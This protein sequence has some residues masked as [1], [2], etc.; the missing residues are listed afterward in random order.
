MAAERPTDRTPGPGYDLAVDSTGSSLPKSDGIGCSVSQLNYT[1][2]MATPIPLRIENLQTA[3]IRAVGNFKKYDLKLLEL[4][5]HEQAISHRIAVYLER[6]FGIG[7]KA[8]LNVDCE[9]SKHLKDDKIA[10]IEPHY[11]LGKYPRC[12]CN[13]CK[14]LENLEEIE[15]KDF[16]PD[17]VVHTRGNDR[18]NVVAL[19]VKKSRI[20]PFDLAKLRALTLPKGAKVVYGYEL[21]VFLHFQNKEPKYIWFLSGEISAVP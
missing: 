4:A 15:E 20:C 19:E 17:I 1:R 5:V 8:N 14:K 3:V 13:S 12:S 18:K 10:I 16:R 21:G 6:L 7:T 11:F 2:N 9:Y